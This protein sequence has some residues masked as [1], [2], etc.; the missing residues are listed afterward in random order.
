MSILKKLR[1]DCGTEDLSVNPDAT[2]KAMDARYSLSSTRV[3]LSA[4]R[5]AYPGAK[6]FEEAMKSRYRT[7]RDL[8]E[9]Q[10]PT[11]AQVDNF[12][13]WDNI[14]DFRDL[15][16]DDMTL[17]QRLLLALY[18]YIPPVR[19]DYTP[20]RIVNRKPTAFEAGHNYLVWNTQPYFIFHA[21]KTAARYGDK[22]VK[23]PTALKRELSVY[24]NNFIDNEYLF[25][26]KGLPWSPTRLS[27][28]LRKI[29][30][31]F[32]QLDTGINLIRHAY[33]TKY[34]AGQKPLAELKKVASAM[35][36]GPMLSQG[37]RFL[38][39]E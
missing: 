25:E 38:S 29:F 7:Y 37:Y 17:A 21:Y 11:S 12:V 20:M 4:L 39:L 31:Q 27:V 23:I 3:A 15:Y 1:G 24:L 8:D 14:I 19:A 34:H 30:Q 22:Y 35:M 32:H 16:Y 33:L 36:H 26:S 2:I 28:E 18:T 13:S 5:K 10:E 9:D 6:K